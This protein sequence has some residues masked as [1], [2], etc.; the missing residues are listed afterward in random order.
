MF[1]KHYQDDGNK[2]C[3]M[4]H[5]FGEVSWGRLRESYLFDGLFRLLS[6]QH[7][8]RDISVL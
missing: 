7:L 4:R 2:R 3:E 5:S 1:E 8:L 6:F